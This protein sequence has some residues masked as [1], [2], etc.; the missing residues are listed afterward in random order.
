MHGKETSELNAMREQQTVASM[1]PHSRSTVLFKCDFP[2]HF[3]MFM[4]GTEP[5]TN[6][7]RNNDCVSSQRNERLTLQTSQTVMNMY[8]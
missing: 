1:R 3:I 2:V 6:F 8:P 4:G 7:M 5:K